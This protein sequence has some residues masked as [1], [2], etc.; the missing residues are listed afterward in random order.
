MC[1]SLW[2]LF[3]D[4]CRDSAAYQLLTGAAV[5]LSKSECHRLPLFCSFANRTFK[6]QLGYVS[7]GTSYYFCA[8]SND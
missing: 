3:G 7:A 4:C 1:L 8:L 6:C 5:L 2:L